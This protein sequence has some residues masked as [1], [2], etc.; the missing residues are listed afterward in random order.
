MIQD[1]G[2][3]VI[4]KEETYLKWIHCFN[5]RE[6][7]LTSAVHVVP[8]VGDVLMGKNVLR[9]FRLSVPW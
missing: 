6:V 8:V 9:R 3:Y 1:V 2:I 4:H 7:E 5:R